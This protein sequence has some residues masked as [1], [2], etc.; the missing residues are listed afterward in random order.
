MTRKQADD[1]LGALLES[2]Q[3]HASDGVGILLFD[4]DA[5]HATGTYAAIEGAARPFFIA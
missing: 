3:L 1:E 5:K 4:W 2:F